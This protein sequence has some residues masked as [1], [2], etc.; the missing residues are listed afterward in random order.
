MPGKQLV[1]VTWLVSMGS[2]LGNDDQWLL[3]ALEGRKG[4]S[5][6][7]NLPHPE[8]A[9]GLTQAHKRLARTQSL[10]GG[11]GPGEPESHSLSWDTAQDLPKAHTWADRTFRKHHCHCVLGILPHPTLRVYLP[12]SVPEPQT[13]KYP[14]SCP[15]DQ[16][17]PE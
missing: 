3:T 2:G 13:G 12:E 8:P 11:E 1:T 7:S 6:P 17:G 14:T 5:L 4:G 10:L 15:P 16:A 9:Q